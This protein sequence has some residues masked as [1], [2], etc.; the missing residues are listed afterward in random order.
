VAVFIVDP[1]LLAISSVG[2]GVIIFF[3]IFLMGDGLGVFIVGV[4]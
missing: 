1:E 2:V 3:I 4:F